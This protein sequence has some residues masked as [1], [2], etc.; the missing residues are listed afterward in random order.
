MLLT[1]SILQQFGAFLGAASEVTYRESTGDKSVTVDQFE[2]RVLHS[3]YPPA[4][5]TRAGGAINDEK[6]SNFN[7]Y[8]LDNSS[9]EFVLHSLA[10]KYP[11]IK[12]NELRLYFNRESKFYPEPGNIWFIFLKRD[13]EI[14]YIGFL[15]R[16]QWNDLDTSMENSEIEDNQL[17]DES[18]ESYQKLIY[19]PQVQAGSAIYHV[20]K[21]IRNP[22]LAANIINDCHNLCQFNQQHPTFI[23]DSSGKPYVEAHHLIPI[24]KS[25]YFKY[26]LDVEANIIIL[27]PQCHKTIHLAIAETKLEYLK[28]FYYERIDVLTQSGIPVSFKNLCEYYNI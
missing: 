14:P 8:V 10:I 18:D 4:S 24:S 11:K 19:S 21:F 7:F 13:D 12:G 27:C 25:I 1:E 6:P 17:I 3:L 20:K 5:F 23:S 2:K 16:E 26:S 15:T 28:R 22:L 9:N